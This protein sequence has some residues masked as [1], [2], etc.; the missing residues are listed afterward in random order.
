MRPIRQ[1]RFRVDTAR[2]VAADKRYCYRPGIG[3]A[4][5]ERGYISGET[6]LALAQRRVLTNYALAEAKQLTR[7]VLDYHLQGKVLKS[8]EVLTKVIKYLQ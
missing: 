7:A 2:P 6:L 3:I 4:G 1:Y 8:R 5:N